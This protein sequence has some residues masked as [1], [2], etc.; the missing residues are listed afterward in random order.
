MVREPRGSATVPGIAHQT[1]QNA[2]GRAA[3]ARG[4][5]EYQNGVKATQK[6]KL[7]SQQEDYHD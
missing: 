1:R 4:V 6:T 2:P 7:L 3:R 5:S